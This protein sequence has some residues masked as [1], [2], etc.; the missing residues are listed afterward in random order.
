MKKNLEI[1]RAQLTAL[2]PVFIGS[3]SE[4]SKK[5]YL[6]LNGRREVGIIDIQ[7]FY[8]V[9][10]QKGLRSRFEMFMMD[11]GTRTNLSGWIR[12]NGIREQEIKKCLKY[13]IDS[14]DTDIQRGTPIHIMECVK[15]PYGMPYIPG[16][17]IKG[18][19][20][21]ILLNGRMIR[22]PERFKQGKEA[23]LRAVLNAPPKVNRNQFLRNEKNMMEKTCFYSL[24]RNEKKHDDAVNDEL[25]GMIISDSEAL[26]LQELVLCQKIE[27]H[28]DGTEKK[29]NLLRECIRPGTRINFN[30]TLEK[31]ICP[32]RREDILKTIESFN[33]VY[34]NCFLKAFRGMDYPKQGQVYLGGGIGFVSKTLIYPLLGKKEGL[35]TTMK[36]FQ[37]TGVPR[38]HKHYKD[39]AYG[40]SPHIVKCT[41]YQ[42]QCMQMGCCK[43][44]FL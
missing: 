11:A 30:I 23:L 26:T 18:M 36:I 25:S 34:Y 4:L 32:V 29:L 27:R 16:S 43:L 40:A 2:S 7:T 31:D 37:C 15:D 33:D 39:T 35:D 14:G 3:G 8:R 44:E 20:R 28:T 19:L 24:H 5:E 38:E 22:N 10:S 41:N 13:T 21:T 12:E 6:F 17:S 42:G 9:I 1:Y